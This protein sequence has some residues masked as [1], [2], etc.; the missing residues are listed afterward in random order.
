MLE[1]EFT[2]ELWDILESYSDAKIIENIKYLMRRENLWKD[3]MSIIFPLGSYEYRDI[4]DFYQ[5]DFEVFA[6]D[7]RT[8]LYYGTAYGTRL[9]EFGVFIDLT[10]ELSAPRS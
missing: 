6:E 4:E 9:R 10:I 2:F 5:K 8:I 7:M 3:G 1:T